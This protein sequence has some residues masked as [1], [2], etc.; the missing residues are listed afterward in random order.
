MA[1]YVL[2]IPWMVGFGG[3]STRRTK[4]QPLVL[5]RRPHE[6]VKCDAADVSSYMWVERSRWLDNDPKLVE[7]IVD[8]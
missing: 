3:R 2:D 4:G 6:S 5:R 8:D 1:R 7:A